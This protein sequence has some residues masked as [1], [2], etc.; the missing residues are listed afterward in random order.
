MRGTCGTLRVVSWE[1]DIEALVERTVRRV[2][3]EELHAELIAPVQ[4]G[5]VVGRS[6]KTICH[7]MAQGLL[8]RH[9]PGPRP[10]VSRRELLALELEAAPRRA[11]TPRTRKAAPRS[12]LAMSEWGERPLEQQVPFRTLPGQKAAPCNERPGQEAI[13]GNG[14]FASRNG[15]PPCGDLF[16]TGTSVTPPSPQPPGQPNPALT[17]GRT[18][19]GKRPVVD[20]GSAFLSTKCP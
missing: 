5:A 2:L 15:K 10:L 9:G 19:S 18:S 8:Q 14:W 11:R 7:W 17:A 1:A 6:A 4:V 16:G 3:R 20:S 13:N 12:L